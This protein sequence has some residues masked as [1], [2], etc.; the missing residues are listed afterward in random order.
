MTKDQMNRIIAEALRSYGWLDTNCPLPVYIANAIADALPM[1]HPN[2]HDDN[3]VI[4]AL[5][6]KLDF[7]E[8]EVIYLRNEGHAKE[9]HKAALRDEIDRL[10]SSI[11]EWKESFGSQKEGYRKLS[12]D[13]EREKASNL[14]LKSKLEE[15]TGVADEFEKE[16]RTLQNDLNSARSKLD[17]RDTEILHLRSAKRD[18]ERENADQQAEIARLKSSINEWKESFEFQKKAL[19]EA[20]ATC[21]TNSERRAF[22]ERKLEEAHAEIARLKHN[23]T[24]CSTK[25]QEAKAAQP[26]FFNPSNHARDCTICGM[27]QFAPQHDVAQWK[28]HAEKAEGNVEASEAHRN[29]LR[30]RLEKAEKRADDNWNLKEKAILRATVAEAAAKRAEQKLASVRVRLDAVIADSTT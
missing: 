15:L 12:S 26:H 24:E 3:P 8:K 9:Q 16:T 2:H 5:R 11:N 21:N 23:L 18:F 13:L 30:R 7:A 1:P 28:A 6:D 29:D 4:I 20:R 27:G 17:T 19:G 22:L 25:L 10:K 14:D